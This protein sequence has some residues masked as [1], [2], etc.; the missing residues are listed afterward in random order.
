MGELLT[1]GQVAQ[2]L[3]LREQSVRAW[4]IYGS[5]PRFTK[6]GGGVRGAVR[7]DRAE[8]ERWLASRTF[9]STAE[10]ETAA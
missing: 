3:G 4:R 10:A 2:L 1:T 8:L 7:Y 5:G 6:I 9:R